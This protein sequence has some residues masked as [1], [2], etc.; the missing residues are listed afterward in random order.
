MA[1][2]GEREINRLRNWL[3]F[4]K[5]EYQQEGK[6]RLGSSKGYTAMFVARGDWERQDGCALQARLSS[7]GI[8]TIS[9]GKLGN[10]KARSRG[11]SRSRHRQQGEQCEKHDFSHKLNRLKVM[12]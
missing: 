11:G 5:D 12:I 1:L 4:L 8:L 2:H 9:T 10:K 3:L 7:D 6:R